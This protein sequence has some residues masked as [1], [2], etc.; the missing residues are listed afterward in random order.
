MSATAVEYPNVGRRPRST[1]ALLL[2]ATVLFP[3]AALACLP[4]AF[5]IATTTF[6]DTNPLL[7]VLGGA[8]VVDAL[9]LGLGWLLYGSRRFRRVALLAE[10]VAIVI[11]ALLLVMSALAGYADEG[12]G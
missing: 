2:V 3:L 7:A 6:N 8:L 9:A 5:G 12:K 1:W 4:I 10:T 11:S